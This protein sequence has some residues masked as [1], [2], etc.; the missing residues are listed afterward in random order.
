MLSCIVGE[1]RVACLGKCLQ[2]LD[3]TAFVLH[4]CC[5]DFDELHFLDA[6]HRNCHHETNVL[7]VTASLTTCGAEFHVDTT[8]IRIIRVRPVIINP[9]RMFG[10]SCQSA[11]TLIRTT[12]GFFI[13]SKVDEAL[14][15]PVGRWNALIEVA[16]HGERLVVVGS[17]TTARDVFVWVNL[18]THY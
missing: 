9:V 10:V 5:F 14:L 2:Q 3:T 8:H 12:C 15:T 11:Q 4:T 6:H 16:V 18:H 1:L 17:I 13:D 7:V